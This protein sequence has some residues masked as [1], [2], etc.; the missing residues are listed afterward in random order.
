MSDHDHHD[1]PH[2][3]HHGHHHPHEHG[4][5]HGPPRSAPDTKFLDL[6]VS[7]VL[8]GEAEGVARHAF[9]ELLVEAAKRRWQERWGD[10]IDALA[11]L[12][13][14]ELL[15]DIEANLTVE[16]AIQGRK[17]NRSAT[18]ERLRAILGGK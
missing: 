7:K 5:G 18:D 9:R 1:G 10:R 6:E 15:A 8:F 16:G 3:H 12:A 11:K 13:V 4:G 14:D 2:H 17:R